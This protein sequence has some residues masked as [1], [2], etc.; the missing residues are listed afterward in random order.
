MFFRDQ[1]IK[2]EQDGGV[3]LP[4]PAQPSRSVSLYVT[5]DVI[6]ET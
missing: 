4:E 3:K 2:L 5:V 1:I 6:F